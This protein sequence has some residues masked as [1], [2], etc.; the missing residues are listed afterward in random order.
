[1]V[2]FL[3]AHRSLGCPTNAI[4]RQRQISGQYVGEPVD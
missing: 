2:E 4:C 3:Q 1:M